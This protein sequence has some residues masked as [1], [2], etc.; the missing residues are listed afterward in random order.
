MGN[1]EFL[2]EGLDMEEH[3]R[4]FDKIIGEY[5]EIVKVTKET[6]II[7]IR[8]ESKEVRKLKKGFVHVSYSKN[9]DSYMIE[10]LKIG[11]RYL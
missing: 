7:D 8:S 4:R 3:N 6:T 11:N 2:R 9:Y 1:R 5:K 10:W